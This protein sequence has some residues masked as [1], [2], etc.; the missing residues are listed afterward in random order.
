MQSKGDDPFLSV[1]LP[2][3]LAVVMG[4]TLVLMGFIFLALAGLGAITP[5]NQTPVWVWF[6]LAVISELVGVF[7]MRWALKGTPEPGAYG[8]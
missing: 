5:T 1:A 3:I 4:F 6:L 7:L 8:P 2:F